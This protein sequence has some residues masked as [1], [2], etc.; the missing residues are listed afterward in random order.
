MR[1]EGTGSGRT[2]GIIALTA[3]VATTVV[4][5][6]FTVTAVAIT[7]QK[8]LDQILPDTTIAVATLPTSNAALAGLMPGLEST[9]RGRL[10]DLGISLTSRQDGRCATAAEST[11]SQVPTSPAGATLAVLSP[12]FNAA[13]RLR[14]HPSTA[15]V[16]RTLVRN[17]A[18]IAPLDIHLT[19]PMLL[20]NNSGFPSTTGWRLY[21][22]VRIFTVGL[23][24][25]SESAL[26][27]SVYYAAEFEGYVIAAGRLAPLESIIDAGRGDAPSLSSVRRA[28]RQ[29][30]RAADT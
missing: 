18:V 22:G 24:S 8:H 3:T 1:G 23:G 14:T 13:R 19:I 16:I 7:P 4:V 9:V 5:A 20:T 15:A 30:E 26:A 28:A 2:L 12:S 27:P 21:R 6:L 10:A 25:C 17:L 29:I 11:V